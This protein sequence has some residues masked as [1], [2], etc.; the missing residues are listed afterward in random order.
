MPFAYRQ[1][2][3]VLPR[4]TP[5]R[6][7]VSDQAVL[8]G[9]ELSNE[10]GIDPAY[11]V[12]NSD[13]TCELPHPVIHCDPNHLLHACLSLSQNHPGAVLVHVSGYGYSMDGAPTHLAEAL[14][15]LRRSGQFC[16]AS[17]FHELFATAMPWKSAF[18]NSL[19]QKRAMRMIVEESDL[20]LTNIKNHAQWL[21]QEAAGL[22]SLPVE[23]LPVLSAAGESQAPISVN[24]RKPAMAVFG[25]FA[26]RQR[27][28]RSL[29]SLKE[30]LNDLGTREIV[31]IGPE[32]GIPSEVSGIPVRRAGMLST[33]DL[34]SELSQTRFGFFSYGRQAL[35][36]SSI[37]AAYCAQGTIPIIAR[38]FHGEVD[39]LTDGV[40]LL[41]PRTAKSAKASELER[42]SLAAWRWYQGHNLRVHAATYARWLN[43]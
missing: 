41:S 15:E 26:S 16:I 17:Y 27:A 5:T 18:W 36:K 38:P 40:Q 14:A 37:L 43:N 29:S 8:L 11:V 23:V 9:R 39:G 6:C 12:L 31:D 33:E 42:Y 30:M 24:E 28:Y 13:A 32:S 22:S 3:Q 34:G 10:F 21:E 25:L 19:R 20:L 35:A 1:L 7:G 4:L 2:I